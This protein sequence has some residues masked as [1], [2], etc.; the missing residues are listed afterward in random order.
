MY[1]VKKRD[2]SIADFNLAKIRD[3]IVKAFEAESTDYTDDI[4]DMLALK[5]TANFASKIKDGVISVEDIQ[6]SVE[7]ILIQA[8]YADVAKAYIL[9]RKQH[10]RIREMKSTILDYKK[11]VDDYLKISL[12]DQPAQYPVSIERS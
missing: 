8:G 9:Y 7:V 5:V 1:Q 12:S 10:T 4:I 2:G 6:D 3:A 11:I